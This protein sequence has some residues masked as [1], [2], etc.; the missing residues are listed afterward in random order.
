M[1]VTILKGQQKA[2]DITGKVYEI[3]G[4]EIR[5]PNN[6]PSVFYDKEDPFY[7]AAAAEN[8]ESESVF[9]SN[10]KINLL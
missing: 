7:K 5:K 8:T 1:K 4:I 6:A 10:G 3:H 9:L 2:K